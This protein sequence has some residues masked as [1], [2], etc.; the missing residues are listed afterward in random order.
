[1]RGIRAVR[2]RSSG[3][4]SRGRAGTLAAP[5]PGSSAGRRFNLNPVPKMFN[6]LTHLN[7]VAVLVTAA[8]GF[9]FGWLWYSPVLFA[10][11]WMTEMKLTPEKMRE[12]AAQGMAKFFA[13][14][15]VYTVVSTFGLATLLKAHGSVGWWRGAEL[16]AFV[17]LVIVGVR[18]ANAGVWERRSPRLLAITV[19]HEVVLFALQGAILAAWTAP[20]I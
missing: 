16:G 10:K 5:A 19:G 17:G 11:P 3:F 14:S 7:W 2:L 13:T 6:A 8:V 9:L 1:V 18:L 4:I 12:V 15:L 20:V